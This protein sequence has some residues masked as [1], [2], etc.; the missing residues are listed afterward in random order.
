MKKIIDW[1]VKI[2][3]LLGAVI[4]V[5][6]ILCTFLG[7]IFRYLFNAP[8]TWEEE[9]Q[10]ACM[11]WITFIAAPVAFHS[12]SHVAIEI[13]VDALPKKV[14]RVVEILIFVVVYAVLI[15]FF[16]RSIEFIESIA[17]TGRVTPMLRI[18]YSLIYGI[19]PVSIVLM[20][21]SFTY[22]TVTETFSK[23]SS[24]ETKEDNK[25]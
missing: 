15:F 17:R 6:L 25:E 10:L 20:L 11:V 3:T 4:L 9:I 5:L 2:E 13:L 21:I 19:A 12:K 16:F 8:F 14:E 1:V 7:V 18:P 23:R 24:A 22:M